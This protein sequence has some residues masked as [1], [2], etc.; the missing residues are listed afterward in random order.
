MTTALDLITRSLKD[1]SV[2]DSIETPSADQAAD[3]LVFLNDLISAWSNEGC[4]VYTQTPNVLTL[5]GSQAYTV[6]SGGTF[7]TPRP[8]V[9][10]Y[11]YYALSGVDY[12]VEI[13]TG[14]QYSRITY[15]ASGGIP[16]C[17]AFN[18]DVPLSTMYIYPVPSTGTLVVV[19][20]SPMTGLATLTTVLAFPNGYE[21]AFR[22]S[23]DVEMMPTYGAFNQQ[24]VAMAEDAKAAIKRINYRPGILTPRVPLGRNRDTFI[25]MWWRP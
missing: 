15:K 11:A 23:L 25:D 8:I 3:G 19:S 7:N 20:Q 22:L 9:P 6:G 13:I 24:L 4:M 1:L 2:L 18:T 12:P 5:T 10:I 14:E 16:T 17:I 21:R